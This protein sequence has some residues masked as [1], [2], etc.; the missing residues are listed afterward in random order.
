MPFVTP[1]AAG[2]YARPSSLGDVMIQVRDVF[3]A[4][5][6]ATPVVV[7]KHYLEQ[8]GVGSYPRVLFVPD[9][10][11]SAG[12]PLEMG[13]A[14][15]VTHSCDVHVR[16][17]ERGDDFERFRE[18]YALADRVMSAIRRAA[19]GRLVFGAYRDGSAT[20]VDDG[21]GAEIVFDFTYQR[22]VLHDTGVVAVAAAGAS[23]TEQGPGGMQTGEA[24]NDATIGV[25][26]TP[27]EVA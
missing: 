11:G 18:T 4:A 9:L 17:P 12:P 10:A 16:G 13:N 27:T 15:S 2:L 1:T 6:D 23:T 24:A 3:S 14:A 19:S 22:D 5:A 21:A 25:V 20:N 26:V 7:G 8:R